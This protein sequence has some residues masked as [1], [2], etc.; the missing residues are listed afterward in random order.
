MKN[1]WKSFFIP[2]TA[3]VMFKPRLG[4][5]TKD[6]VKMILKN[7]DKRNHQNILDLCCG[8]GRHSVEF[9]KKHNV[10]GLDFSKHFL[11]RAR[12]K[13]GIQKNIKFIQGDM[14][15][16]SNY[17]KPA[18]FDVAV[19]LYNSFG[20]FDKKSDDQKV[21][22]EVNKVLKPNGFFIINTLNGSGVLKRLGHLKPTHNGYELEKNL[23][24]LDSAFFNKFQKRTLSKWTIIDARG[25]HVKIYRKKFRQN[26]YDHNEL[27]AMLEKSGFKIIK[28]WSILS[29]DKFYEKKSWHQTI[30][31]KKI[32]P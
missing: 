27:K 26:V 18:T 22:N 9:S 19:S 24:M 28:T 14:K 17:F 12:A 1:W 6:E 5:Q 7:I 2:I 21:L 4:K 20:Y 25:N 30:L 8:E 16:L 13:L 11:K 31:A 10:T 32:K 29:G 23:F 15:C 3:E